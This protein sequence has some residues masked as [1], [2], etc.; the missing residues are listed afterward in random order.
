MAVQDQSAPVIERDL[1]IGNEW[2]PSADGRSQSLVNPATEEEF[3][4]VAPASSADVDAAVQAARQRQP[5]PP[6]K[7]A[8]PWARPS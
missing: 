1:F 5:S 4:R 6:S 2:R 3:G 8:T 7:P